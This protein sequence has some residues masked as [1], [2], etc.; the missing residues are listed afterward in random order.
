MIL[1]FFNEETSNIPDYAFGDYYEPPHG[2]VGELY[3]IPSSG[4]VAGIELRMLPPF[5]RDNHTIAFWPFPGRARL[6]CLTM[7]VSDAANQLTGLMDLN[8]FPRVGDREFLP[9]NKTIYYWQQDE[10]KQVKPPGQIHVMTSIIKSK[11]ALRETGDILNK[12]KND[13]DYKELIDR[14]GAIITE[15][16]S[17]SAVTN[18]TMQ[19]AHIVGQYLGKVDDQPIGTVIN[20]FTRLH[21]DWD[22]L[23][24]TPVSVPT[25][26]VDFQYEL[27]IRDHQRVEMAKSGTLVLPVAHRSSPEGTCEM[28]PM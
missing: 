23:G 13:N 20:S 26:D 10:L 6:Y 18:L 15:T 2:R 17:F 28:V 16:A 3:S 1:D 12:V 25:R 14:L 27:I 7:V 24:I 22:R 4:D 21:G 9:I 11:E 8:G 19:A 5:I